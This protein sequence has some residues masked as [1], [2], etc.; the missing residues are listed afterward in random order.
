MTDLT[1]AVLLSI[2][3]SF[4]EV[5]WVLLFGFTLTGMK[6][7]IKNVILIALIQT[8]IAFLVNILNIRLG[9]H[10]II[11]S[12]TTCLLVALVLKIKLYH[13][14]LPVLI[15]VFTQGIMQVTLYSLVIFLFS[16]FDAT[17]LC[18]NFKITFIFQI[19]IIILSILL[20]LVVK[21]KNITIL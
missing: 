13:A 20:L 15:G 19:P 9:I 8:L 17:Q 3:I 14:M 10:T 11:Q 5:I 16:Q 4:P 2:F 7:K 6:V 1:N 21:K 18:V 12:A